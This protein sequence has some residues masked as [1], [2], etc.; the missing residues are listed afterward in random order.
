MTLSCPSHPFE[1]NA[2]KQE[3][4]L[5]LIIQPGASNTIR[6]GL[7]QGRIKIRLAA[8]PIE[9]RANAMLIRWLAEQFQVPQKQV[10]C[11][12]GAS[13]RWKKM[14]IDRPRFPQDWPW[15]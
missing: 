13:T 8:P 11:V 12:Q 9:G 2:T 3:L 6:T 10:C 7:H 14:R 15:E 5:W 1:W 4:S